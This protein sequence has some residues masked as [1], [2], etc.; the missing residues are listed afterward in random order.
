MPVLAAFAEFARAVRARSP[1]TAVVL[2][3]GLGG[4]ATAFVPHA[5][6]GFGDIPGLVPP[7]VQGHGGKLALGEWAGEPALLF[8]GRLHVYEGHPWPTVTGAVRTIAELGATRIVLTN[9]AGGIHPALHPGGLMAIR[10]HI[11]L[12]GPTAWRAL[13]SGKKALSPYS[14]HLLDAL[15]AHESAAGRDLL[16]G[17]YATLTGPSYETPAEIRALAAIGADAVGMSTALEA[18]EAAQLGLEVAAISCITNKAAGL[19]A[20][21]LDHTEVLTNAQLAVSRMAELLACLVRARP[22]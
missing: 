6:I 17:V 10:G 20:T 9:A 8:S 21:A 5:S 3:S 19:G 4:A 1:R 2:G 11:K 16:A 13:A 22:A 7:S 14:L 12:L 15:H 18:E